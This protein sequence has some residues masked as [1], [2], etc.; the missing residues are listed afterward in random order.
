L[1]VRSHEA[2]TWLRYLSRGDVV[3][4][5]VRLSEEALQQTPQT[6]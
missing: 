1:F 5:H 3:S 6:R 4:L 2:F